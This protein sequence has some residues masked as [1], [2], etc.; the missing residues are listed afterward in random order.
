MENQRL[1]AIIDRLNVRG[2][3]SRDSD[4]ASQLSDLS[5]YGHREVTHLLTTLFT[6]LT[7]LLIPS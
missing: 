2:T 5:G 7:Y 3:D 6:M 1:Y 4:T